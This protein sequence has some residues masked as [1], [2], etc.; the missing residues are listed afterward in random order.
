MYVGML[1]LGAEELAVG[2]VVHITSCPLVTPFFVQLLF[3]KRAQ[4]TTLIATLA[5]STVCRVY[6]ILPRLRCSISNSC[7]TTRDCCLLQA[8]VRHTI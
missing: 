5:S 7:K 3:R 4:H 6:V 8:A 1:A 2:V